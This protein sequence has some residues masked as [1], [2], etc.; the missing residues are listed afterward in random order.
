MPGGLS[1]ND[2]HN[3][4]LREYS[5]SQY[6]EALWYNVH[7]LHALVTDPAEV[8][9]ALGGGEIP[10]LADMLLGTLITSNLL[11]IKQPIHP[12]YHDSERGVGRVVTDRLNSSFGANR[13]V[14][15]IEA[16]GFRV[17]AQVDDPRRTS[18]WSESKF[19]YY[20]DYET[21]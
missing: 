2:R 11:I 6:P 15:Q 20:V 4:Q 16:I 10:G 13:R 18:P 5:W 12:P 19:I 8:E 17:Q 3:L 7:G 14:L 9:S 21:L 1:I